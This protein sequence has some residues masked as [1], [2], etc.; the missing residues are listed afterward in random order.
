CDYSAGELRKQADPGVQAGPLHTAFLPRVTGGMAGVGRGQRAAGEV[1][2]ALHE[3]NYFTNKQT[4]D[5]ESVYEY[6]RLFRDFLL[7]QALRLY[8]PADCARI[9]RTAAGLLVAAGQIEPAARL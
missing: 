3:Q 7:S 8:S 4:N 2:T 6:H 5:G 9:R 1:L